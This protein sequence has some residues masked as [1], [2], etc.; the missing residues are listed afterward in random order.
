MIMNYHNLPW[1]LKRFIVSKQTHNLNFSTDSNKLHLWNGQWPIGIEHNAINVA[2]VEGTDAYLF[3]LS[4][5]S[6]MLVARLLGL[7]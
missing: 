6:I 3:L 5:N 1:S 7:F 4:A 2:W